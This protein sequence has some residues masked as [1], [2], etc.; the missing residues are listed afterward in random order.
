[1]LSRTAETIYW[2]QRYM[3]RAE[4]I[5][6]FIEVNLNLNLDSSTMPMGDQWAPLVRVTGDWDTFI[7]RYGEPTQ[8]NVIEFLAFDREYPFS[9]LSSLYKARE[10]ARSVRQTIS[11]N[12][13]E[14]INSLYLMVTRTNKGLALEMPQPFFARIKAGCQSFVGIT[15]TTMSH[16]EAWHFGR[17]GTFI[18]RADKTSRILDVKYFLL[19]PSLDDVGTPFDNL[20]WGALL[21]SASAFEMYRKRYGP[22]YHRNVVEFLMLDREFPR[23]ILFCLDAAMESLHR[24]SGSQEGAF[25]N[26]VEKR[27]GRLESELSYTTVDDIISHGLHE[28]VDEL[29]TGLNE[30]D[31]AIYET[32]FALR[33][34]E[35]RG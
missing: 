27:L 12:M 5:A 20:Q 24:I 21:S 1:M 3:E 4:N 23:A 18:E 32:F 35:E 7:E 15:D 9:L 22:I 14:Q 10:G 34:I 8:E 33:P 30:V 19:L 13:W 2:M 31:T 26:S 28:Y 11:S 6:R 25:G 16:G 17:L 29:Q